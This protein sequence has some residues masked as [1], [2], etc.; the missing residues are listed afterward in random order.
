MCLGVAR[1]V[2]VVDFAVGSDGYATVSG[3]VCSGCRK[4]G[5]RAHG[6]GNTVGVGEHVQ[7]G[8][9][10]GDEL[11]LEQLRVVLERETTDSGAIAL[12]D[13]A[14]SPLDLRDMFICRRDVQTDA[15]EFEQ[16]VSETLEFFVGVCHDYLE[17]S[18]LAQLI[19]SIQTREDV[20]DDGTVRDVL[21]GDEVEAARDRAD[22]G[23]SVD[24]ENHSR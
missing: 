9:S 12:L 15:I 1:V 17:S 22:E 2:L 5:A 23:Q 19:Y 21:G 20:L 3:V 4:N 7:P 16:Q 10:L 8:Y 14:N 13:S 24:K 11:E 6:G 18:G